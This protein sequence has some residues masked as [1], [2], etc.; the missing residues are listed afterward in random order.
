[1]NKWTELIVGLI[2]VIGAIIIAWYSQG[3]SW[4]FWHAAGTFFLGGLFWLVIMIGALF[5]LLGIS[6]LKG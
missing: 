5:I 1:M 2:L 6:D 4:D 3:W